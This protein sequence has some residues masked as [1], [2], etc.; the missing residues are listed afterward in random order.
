MSLGKRDISK[1][2]STKTQISSED[3]LKILNKFIDV[4]RLES[5]KKPVKL[6]KF[7]T[8]FIHYSPKRLGRNPKTKEEFLISKRSK[9]S[10]KISSTI[11]NFLN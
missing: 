1:N 9:L 3:S 7:G 2:I 10:L 11:R 4:I 5:K 6:S 8:F